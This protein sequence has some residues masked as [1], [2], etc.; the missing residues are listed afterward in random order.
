[1][2]MTKSKLTSLATAAA[3]TA[4]LFALSARAEAAD[5][6][7][8]SAPMAQKAS[9]NMAAGV[10]KA[11]ARFMTTAAASGLYEVEVS[12]LAAS[13]GSADQLKA[14][15]A[16]LVEHHTAANTELM[17]LAQA[18][19]VALPTA[20]PAPKQA[21]MDRLS[22]MNGKAFD[23]AFIQQVGI[24]DH[25]EDIA[26]FDSAS[27]T[28]PDAEVKGFAAKTLPTLRQHLSEAQTLP[29]KISGGSTAGP[30]A[31]DAPKP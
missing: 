21:N 5:A 2:H 30:H 14:F 8:A 9:G 4:S 25:R 22:K 15:A 24:K 27:K 20:I 26:L 17:A 1:M 19:G 16:M 23:T 6:P 31:V 18:K 29:K 28:L 12:K 7:K 10:H 11:S 3:L 13:R